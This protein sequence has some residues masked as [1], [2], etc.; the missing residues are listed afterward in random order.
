MESCST[1]N[2]TGAEPGTTPVRCPDCGGSGQIRRAQQSIFGSF[3]NVTTCPR[4]GGNGEVVTTPC[5]TCHG[6]R[7]VETTRKLAVDIPGG[8]DDGM[9]VRLAGEG[10]AGLNGGPAGNL[11][12][13]VRV[14]PHEF[15]RR[16]E[17]D[18]LLNLNINIVQATLGD[19]IQV[20]TLGMDHTL[21]IP[22]GTQPGAVFRLRGEG[23]ARLRGSGRGDEIVVVNVAFPTR[24]DDEQKL[25]LVELGQ[26]LGD[27]VIPQ[28]SKSFVDRLKNALGI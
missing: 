17:D 16:R 2:G 8:V 25:L 19:Q 10:E 15:F 23:V 5:T 7:R 20:P 14:Q 28:T 18:L 21:T 22:A 12:V 4:C 6:S 27:D 26:T 11:Y 13:L 3:V 24:L 9:R 1:C